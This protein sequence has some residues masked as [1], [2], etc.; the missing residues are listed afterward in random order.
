MGWLGGRTA[1]GT[2][3][4]LVRGV[5]V[6]ASGDDACDGNPRGD[7]P[8][9]LPVCRAP[10]NAQVSA[11]TQRIP[12]ARVGT[13]AAARCSTDRAHRRGRRLPTRRH[14]LAN[15]ERMVRIA[16]SSSESR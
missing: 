1:S 12:G 3:R 6:R 14:I 9:A 15:R 7:A 11:I 10:Y 16:F 5:V 2:R 8:A 13:V 4:K